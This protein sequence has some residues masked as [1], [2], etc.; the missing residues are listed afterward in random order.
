MVLLIAIIVMLPWTLRNFRVFGEVVPVSTNGG[1]TLLTGNN[2]SARGGYT[3]DD[4]LVTTLVRTV[5]T[6]LQVD[7]EARARAQKWIA[8]NPSRFVALMPLK[9]F[10]LWAPDGEAEWAYQDGYARY[11]QY[12]LVFRTVRVI[13]QIY[14]TALLLGF[15]W[16]A[17]LMFLRRATIS[18]RAIDWWA[19]PYALALF[20]SLIALVFSGQSRF[21][22]P[23][24][25]FVAMSCAGLLTRQ[26]TRTA[27]ESSSSP[28]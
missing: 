12:R 2:P 20:P 26:A 14:Y 17:A 9:L 15:A 21:H 22:Y 8:E 6:Q 11:D 5:A 1:M 28:S 19:L 7:R 24:M 13:N 10:R 27:P 18:Q 25:P 23:V 16:A 3:E 4:P